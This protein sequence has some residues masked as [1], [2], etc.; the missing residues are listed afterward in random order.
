MNIKTGFGLLICSLIA[1]SVAAQ[2]DSL[3]ALSTQELQDSQKIGDQFKSAETAF[4]K[5]P[6][7]ESRNAY[8]KA[9]NEMF[10]R[11]EAYAKA[12]V[13][14]QEACVAGNNPAC[15]K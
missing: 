7:D 13:L 14:E 5:A 12:K 6:S 2:S 10:D 3:S 15:Q 1:T 9:R 4:L 8:F 11:A